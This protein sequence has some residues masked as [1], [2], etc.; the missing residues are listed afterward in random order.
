M[1]WPQRLTS[2]PPSLSSEPDAT[3]KFLKDTKHWS[4][5]VSDVYTD[6]LSINWS[7]VRNVMD[8]NAGYAG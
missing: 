5:L 4:E 6:G 8:M 2:I 3:E 1:S 7:S